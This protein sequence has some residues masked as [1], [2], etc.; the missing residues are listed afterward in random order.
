M[1]TEEYNEKILL[2][3]RIGDLSLEGVLY[4]EYGAAFLEWLGEPSYDNG[5]GYTESLYGDFWAWFTSR[6]LNNGEFV[7]ECVELQ[8]QSLDREI[9]STF[10]RNS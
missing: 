1:T 4:A 3:A 10:A 6:V 8:V 2:V 7:D 5:I 9:Q